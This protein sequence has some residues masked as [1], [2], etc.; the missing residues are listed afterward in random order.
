MK[1]INVKASTYIDFNI[2]NNDKDPK[3][4]L[5]ILK[6]QIYQNIVFFEKDCTP[7]WS[8]EFFVITKVKNNVPWTYV[9]EDINGEKVVGKLVNQKEFRIEKVIQKKGDKIF[10]QYKCCNNSFNSWIDKK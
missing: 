7:N 1:P 3:I 5:A 8:E 2:G 10:V 6:Y 4:K 9:I